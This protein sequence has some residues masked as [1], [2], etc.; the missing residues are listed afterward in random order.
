MENDDFPVRL[1]RI[2]FHIEGDVLEKLR[3]P[4]RLK[5]AVQ[6]FRAVGIALA[7]KNARLKRV[8]LDSAISVEFNAADDVLRSARFLRLL[9]PKGL[10]ECEGQQTHNDENSA[11]A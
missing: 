2:I 10:A 3:V 6:R 11:C 4:Q 9:S 5:I 8:A 7:R 1:V